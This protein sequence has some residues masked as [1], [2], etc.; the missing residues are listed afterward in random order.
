MWTY[1]FQTTSQ[2]YQDACDLLDLYEDTKSLLMSEAF[3]DN[4]S[5][6]TASSRAASVVG[7][8]TTDADKEVG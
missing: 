1:L 4:A 7:S 5:A 6:K 8:D 2:E 3:G